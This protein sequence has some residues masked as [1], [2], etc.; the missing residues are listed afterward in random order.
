MPEYDISYGN[1]DVTPR[2]STIRVF[3]L[4]ERWALKAA[5]D[6]LDSV[7]ADGQPAAWTVIDIQKVEEPPEPER[8]FEG[9]PNGAA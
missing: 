8:I 7:S 1:Y 4:D 2:V 5:H 6:Q 9:V 3:G